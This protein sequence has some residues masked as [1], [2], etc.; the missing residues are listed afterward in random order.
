LLNGNKYYD[1]EKEKE[2]NDEKF[3]RTF[4]EKL[5]NGVTSLEIAE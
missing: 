2:R 5:K 1:I 3:L 4:Y